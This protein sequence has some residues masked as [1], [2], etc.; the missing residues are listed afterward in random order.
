MQNRNDPIM[1]NM[2]VVLLLRKFKECPAKHSLAQVFNIVT[3]NPNIRIS[4]N[5]Q[6]IK[7]CCRD[8]SN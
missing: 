6:N 1:D 4:I 7:Q 8:K 5:T 2:S 3:N